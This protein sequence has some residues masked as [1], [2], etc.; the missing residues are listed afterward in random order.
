MSS[1]PPEQQAEEKDEAVAPEP[2]L[3]PMVEPSVRLQ[4]DSYPKRERLLGRVRREPGIPE[5]Q[6]ALELGGEPS[7]DGGEP[8]MDDARFHVEVL[9]NEGLIDR[10]PRDVPWGQARLFSPGDVWLYD[11]DPFH[12]LVEHRILLD[13]ALAVAT[14]GP[15]SVRRLAEETARPYPWARILLAWLSFR[16]LVEKAEEANGYVGTDRLD[17]WCKAIED[18]PLANP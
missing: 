3:A 4:V 12:K 8:E 11:Q 6:L 15:A 5:E 9:H 16:G 18:T 2:D 10:R 14:H 1:P 7:G 17:R 13:M